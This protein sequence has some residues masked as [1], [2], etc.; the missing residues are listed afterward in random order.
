MPASET[1]SPASFLQKSLSE[2]SRLARLAAQG[3]FFIDQSYF[4]GLLR[5]KSSFCPR[6]GDTSPGTAWWRRPRRC[7][8]ASCHGYVSK[9]NNWSAVNPISTGGF[10]E[11]LATLL[12]RD[13]PGLSAGT[14][15]RLNALWQE[16]HARWEQRTL[17]HN[18]TLQNS[19]SFSCCHRT[20]D[21]QHAPHWRGCFNCNSFT[22]MPTTS[23][24]SAGIEASGKR[25]I[26]RLDPSSSTSIVLRQASLWLSLISRKEGK[27]T[28]ARNSGK[29]GNRSRKVLE[30]LRRLREYL[31]RCGELN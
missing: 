26:C 18:R 8:D 10:S 22:R 11:A 5:P 7:P 1:C 30:E 12:G 23:A 31:R 21:S 25:A 17:T 3:D 19:S 14:S 27:A 15:S 9:R 2:R 4:C 6:Y 28:S 24:A 29:H 13:A 20:L 16:E